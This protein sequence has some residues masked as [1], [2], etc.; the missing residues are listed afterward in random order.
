MIPSSAGLVFP[1]VVID[2]EATALSLTSYPIEVGVAKMADA[3]AGID[4]WSTLIQPAPDWDMD[5][6]WDRDAQRIHGIHQWDLRSGKPA[7]EAMTMLNTFAGSGAVWCD[8]RHYDVHW[9]RRLTDAAGIEP[10][11]KLADVGALLG[12]L[13]QRERYI[14]LL[15]AT[16][17]P[18]RAGPDAARIC[19][20]LQAS[21]HS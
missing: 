17:A 12:D 5:R 8:G 15:K 6:E 20:A 4:T 13:E 21:L 18:H 19:A 16:P 3:D 10:S 9:L 11:F 14:G 2:F 1:L 7:A